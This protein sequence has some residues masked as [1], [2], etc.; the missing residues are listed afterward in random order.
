ML[1]LELRLASAS[2]LSPSSHLL[3]SFTNEGFGLVLQAHAPLLLVGAGVGHILHHLVEIGIRQGRRTGD[4]DGLLLIAAFV[5]R[6]FVRMPLA[7]MS[8]VTSI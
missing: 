7:S 6:D 4:R 2:T 1:L 3:F 8:K 5:L